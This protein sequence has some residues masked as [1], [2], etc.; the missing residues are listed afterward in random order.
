M[1]MSRRPPSPSASGEPA[2]AF[3][4]AVGQAVLDA[5]GELPRSHRRPSAQALADSQRAARQAGSRAALAAGALALPLGPLGWLTVL[6]ELVTVWRIQARLVADIAALHG[7]AEPVGRE[8]LLVCLFQHTS[9]R[10]LRDLVMQVGERSLVQTVSARTLQLLAARVGA[11]LARRLAGKGLA[12]WLPVVGAM[13]L[14]AFAYWDTQ[15]VARTA[16]ALF[17]PV[18]QPADPTAPGKLP[19]PA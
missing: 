3:A 5:L 18:A 1:T 12:R 10:V 15:Q 7:H 19:P 4:D 17:S 16:I 6:P 14:G 13:G 9:G 8:T 2:S 11:G